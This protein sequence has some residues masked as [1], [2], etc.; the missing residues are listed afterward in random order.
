MFKEIA[1][2]LR[3]GLM[4]E[5]S[6]TVR[7]E[8][9]ASSLGSGLVAA[10][11]TPKLVA[12]IENASVNAVKESI[13]GNATTVGVEVHVKHIA[14]TPVGMRVHAKSELVEAEDRRLLFRAEAWD[15]KEKIG[16]ASHTRILVNFGR[17]EDRLKKK[18]M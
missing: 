17:F 11:S 7:E 9:T 10:F 4:G 8:D 16:E 1:A 13:P 2:T 15:D 14:A 18:A 12:L 5:A 6:Q 3:K